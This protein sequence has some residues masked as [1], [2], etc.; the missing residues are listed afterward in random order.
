MNKHSNGYHITFV[1]VD[2]MLRYG[3][4]LSHVG[5]QEEENFVS[6]CSDAFEWTNVAIWCAPRFNPKASFICTFKSLTVLTFLIIKSL[7][8]SVY[9]TNQGL[10]VPEFAHN[11]NKDTHEQTG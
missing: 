1:K 4:Y 8:D 10:D 11:V 9:L 2:G 5:H 7:T 3:P 6:I